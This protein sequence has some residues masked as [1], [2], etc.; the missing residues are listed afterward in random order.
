MTRDGAMSSCAWCELDVDTS[1]RQSI[2][3]S[4]TQPPWS[5]RAAFGTVGAVAAT[6]A[7]FA[8]T[9][10]ALTSEEAPIVL[11][12]HRPCWRSFLELLGA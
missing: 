8:S 2:R 7:A 6:G 3:L 4:N 11:W 1:D 12:F 9:L 5:T 10:R